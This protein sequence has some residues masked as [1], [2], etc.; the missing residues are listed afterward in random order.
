MKRII[1]LTLSGVFA[2]T[3]LMSFSLSAAECTP[4]EQNNSV[5]TDFECPEQEG[6]LYKMC[7]TY[8]DKCCNAENAES[9]GSS[10]D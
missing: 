1:S 8:W 9:C 5:L 7:V 2:I 3:L 6:Q 10:N 4:Y